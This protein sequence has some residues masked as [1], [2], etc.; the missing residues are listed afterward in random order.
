MAKQ[1]KRNYRKAAKEMAAK[2]NFQDAFADEERGKGCKFPI[3]RVK[4]TN[5]P[6]WYF[7]STQTLKDVASFS[8]SKPLGSELRADLVF[9]D[10]TVEGQEIEGVSG[11][12]KSVPGLLALHIAPTPGIALDAQSPVNLG[13]QNVY[14]AIRYQNSGSNNDI[15]P[16]DYMLY[17]LAMDS[18]YSAWNWAKRIYGFATTYSQDN[19]YYPQAFFRA[20]GVDMSDVMANLADFR[21]YLNLASQRIAAFC[22][23]STFTYMVRHSWLF[24]NIYKDA[25]TTKAQV[26]MYVPSF[27]YTFEETTSEQGGILTPIKV[28]YGMSRYNPTLMKVSDIINMIDTMINNLQYSQD[29]GTMSGDILKAFGK[30]GLFTLSEVTDEYKIEPVYSK[31]VLTQIENSMPLNCEEDTT[32]L[33]VFNITQDVNNNVIKYQPVLPHWVVQNDGKFLNFHWDNP[34]PEDVIVATRLCH[35]ATLSGTSA[36]PVYTLT[37]VGSEICTAAKMYWNTSTTSFNTKYQPGVPMTIQEFPFQHVSIPIRAAVTEL[38]TAIEQA[39]MMVWLA[40]SFDWAPE[41][42]FQ[43]AGTGEGLGVLGRICPPIKDWDVFTRLDF[44]DLENLNL[45]ALQSEFN[46]P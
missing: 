38:A 5:D 16:Q 2:N 29:I 30:S 37:S 46:L 3:S 20:N 14:N 27:F 42:L 18:L 19:W 33:T 17:F 4:P 1:R 36:A 25:D 39:I 34:S 40:T 9:P 12:M 41:Y 24:S 13:A 28:T 8:Y 11:S 7:K 45:L 10:Y 44:P 32:D 23:P 22:V 15:D 21:G 6:Q 31:E 43:L 35:T 26:Y